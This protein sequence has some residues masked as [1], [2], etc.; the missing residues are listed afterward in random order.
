MVPSSAIR[1]GKGVGVGGNSSPVH[2][3]ASDSGGGAATVHSPDATRAG[4]SPTADTPGSVI[5]SSGT[6]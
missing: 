5:R 4:E 1:G 2:V 6:A 3:G